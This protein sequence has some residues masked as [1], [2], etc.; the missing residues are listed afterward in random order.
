VW[1]DRR[2][3]QSS[4]HTT[5]GSIR[6]PLARRHGA[7]ESTVLPAP[8]ALPDYRLAATGEADALE[9]RAAAFSRNVG[10][11]IQRAD[12]YVLAVVLFA[13]SLFF[14]GIS[15]RLHSIGPR[16]AILG[17]GYVLFLGTVVWLATFPVDV[18]V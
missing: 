7:I 17:F 16:A 5:N 18:A 6:P 2:R 13:V 12:N 3:R 8:F 4:P 10:S 11:Y 9:A 15:T 1:P 14:A